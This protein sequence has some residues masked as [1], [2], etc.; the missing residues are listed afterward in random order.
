MQKELS[1]EM[2][3]KKKIREMIL[4]MGFNST[5][6]KGKWSEPWP[7]SKVGMVLNLYMVLMRLAINWAASISSMEFRLA[8]M[9]AIPGS[10]SRII[11]WALF[12]A[13]RAGSIPFWAKG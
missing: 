9:I 4:L 1:Q 8:A 5:G 7:P 3:L 12:T 13:L 6:R 11:C 2:Q 10:P